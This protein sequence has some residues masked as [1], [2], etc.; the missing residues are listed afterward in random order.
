MGQGGD[1][2]P[3][4]GSNPTITTWVVYAGFVSIPWLELLPSQSIAQ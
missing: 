1:A 4:C 2:V 3:H